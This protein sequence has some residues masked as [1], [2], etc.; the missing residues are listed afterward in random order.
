MAKVCLCVCL[1]VACC[2][3]KGAMCICSVYVTKKNNWC[4]HKCESQLMLPF[5][6]E[7]IK[8]CKVLFLELWIKSFY[9]ALKWLF[10]L[11][12][13]EKHCFSILP[14]SSTSMEW[15]QQSY[16]TKTIQERI[17]KVMCLPIAAADTKL[18]V[19]LKGKLM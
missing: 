15:W 18:P 4:I 12:T 2:G 19:S 13:T 8:R 11:V 10:F 17:R 3:C 16:L 1:Y 14:F 7:L 6:Q 5:L 9:N